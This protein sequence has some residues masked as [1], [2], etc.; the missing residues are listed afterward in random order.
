MQIYVV[1]LV[2]SSTVYYAVLLSI[3]VWA[4]N[5]FPFCFHPSKCTDYDGELGYSISKQDEPCDGLYAHVCKNWPFLYPGFQDQRHLLSVRSRYTL[6]AELVKQRDSTVSVL[7]RIAVGFQQCVQVYS[8]KEH[9]VRTVNDLFAKY[10]YE[11]PSLQLRKDF[12]FLEFLVGLTLDYGIA[13]LFR[14]LVLPYFRTDKN[15]A[16]AL[17]RSKGFLQ[18]D[19]EPGSDIRQVNIEACITAF[20]PDSYVSGMDKKITS[21]WDSVTSANRLSDTEYEV[22]YVKIADFKN[23]TPT[24]GYAHWVDTINNHLPDKVRVSGNDEVL[25][26]GGV[27]P[28]L[29]HVIIQFKGKLEDVMLAVGFNLVTRLSAAFSLPVYQCMDDRFNTKDTSSTHKF[30]EPATLSAEHSTSCLNFMDTLAPFAVARTLYDDVL[31]GRSVNMTRDIMGN[32]R[33]AILKTFDKIQD[34]ATLTSAKERLA[35]LVAVVGLPSRLAEMRTIED[36]YSFLPPFNRAFI[37]DYLKAGRLKMDRMKELLAAS[38]DATRRQEI[39]V[40]TIQRESE[41]LLAAH[42]LY[43]PGVLLQAPFIS[44]DLPLSVG[45]GGIGHDVSAAT[46]KAFDPIASSVTSTGE[47]KPLYDEAIETPRI[48]AYYECL[49]TEIALAKG[50]SKALAGAKWRRIFADSTGLSRTALAFKSLKNKGSGLLGYTPEQLL[51]V[52]AGFKFCG[53]DRTRIWD[54]ELP[55]VRATLSATNTKMFHEAFRC[56]VLASRGSCSDPWAPT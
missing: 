3:E 30:V 43:V 49:H 7:D 56:N 39:E 35:T 16:L 26:D 19:Y 11:W 27:V 20:K 53:E 36:M 54:G 17:S 50:G 34:T 42:V 4:N 12:D 22:I 1:L 18:E 14:L 13:T 2:T 48:K 44:H 8:N 25:V 5:T 23:V 45:Y 28:L 40:H 15:Y 52:S 46:M 51:F 55:H 29:R 9:N 33:N 41:Y 37:E 24:I 6:V 21:F 47:Y 32:V 38:A 10:H 31:D